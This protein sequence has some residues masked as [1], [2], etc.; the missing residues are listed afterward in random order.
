[1]RTFSYITLGRILRDLK[2]EGINIPRP[3]YIRWQKKGL[4]PQYEHRQDG[5]WR[6][7]SEEEAE[8]TKAAIRKICR[9]T[10]QQDES[11]E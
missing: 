11:A 7:Y 9:A 1:M 2:D 5:E 4:L 8:E 10:P 6:R 3:T